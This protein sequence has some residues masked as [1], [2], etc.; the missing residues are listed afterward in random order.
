MDESARFKYRNCC[1]CLPQNGHN[2]AEFFRKI[3]FT[4]SRLSAKERRRRRELK[5]FQ[6]ELDRNS[7]IQLPR[8]RPSDIRPSEITGRADKFRYIFD[9][10]WD[11]L[12]PMLKEGR[13]EQQVEEALRSAA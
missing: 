10:V 5:E 13:T 11:R 1:S 7:P 2:S 4:M 9:Q 8:G 3:Q 12:W 6:K